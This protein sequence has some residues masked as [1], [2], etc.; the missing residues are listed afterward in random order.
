MIYQPQILYITKTGLQS[1]IEI[2]SK[3]VL[4]EFQKIYSLL[5]IPEIANAF[6]IKIGIGDP[7]DHKSIKYKK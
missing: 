4:L 5:H 7:M 1:T 2:V 3:V 6:F